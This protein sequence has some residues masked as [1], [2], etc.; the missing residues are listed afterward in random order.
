MFSDP[1]FL[2]KI[3]AL[4]IDSS[5]QYA[6]EFYL[7][8]CTHAEVFPFATT[9]VQDK[10]DLFLAL[11]HH[12]RRILVRYFHKSDLL[13]QLPIKQTRREIRLENGVLTIDVKARAKHNLLGQELPH[14]LTQMPYPRMRLTS[15]RIFIRKV[16]AYVEASVQYINKQRVF[17]GYT[18][19]VPAKL[20]PTRILNTK[21][22]LVK[23]V[24]DTM[25]LPT[26]VENRIDGARFELF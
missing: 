11:L 1:H 5:W 18:I 8:S 20:L 6:L 16:D 12:V 25:W 24:E 17:V 10:A 26:V 3:A 13:R 19:K 22:S 15:D 7:V 21:E 9:S 4:N 23:Y 14:Y 2:A